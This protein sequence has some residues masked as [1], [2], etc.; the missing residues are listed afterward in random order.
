LAEQT[1]VNS[2]QEGRDQEMKPCM[3]TCGRFQHCSNGIHCLLKIQ[4]M[5]QP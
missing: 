5:M 4:T 1:T 3:L 2:L